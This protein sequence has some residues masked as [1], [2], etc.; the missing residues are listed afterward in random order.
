MKSKQSCITQ[1]NLHCLVDTNKHKNTWISKYS[2]H[3]ND[4]LYPEYMFPD[5]HVSQ[6]TPIPTSQTEMTS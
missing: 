1:I 3:L 2:R 5:L 6:F 4:G